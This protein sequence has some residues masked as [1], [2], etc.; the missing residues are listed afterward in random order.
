[1]DRHDCWGTDAFSTCYGCFE[2]KRSVHD[3]ETGYP[4]DWAPSSLSDRRK[5]LRIACMPIALFRVCFSSIFRCYGFEFKKSDEGG[6]DY[7]QQDCAHR[8]GEASD[9]E[10]SL[11][12]SD[13]GVVDSYFNYVEPEC[14]NLRDHAGIESITFE[15]DTL[16]KLADLGSSALDIMK[17]AEGRGSQGDPSHPPSGSLTRTEN[18]AFSGTLPEGTLSHESD[19]MTDVEMKEISKD[20]TGIARLDDGKAQMNALAAS[21]DLG[22]T[23]TPPVPFSPVSETI[24]S[25]FNSGSNSK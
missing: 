9:D 16:G 22:I 23:S 2:A 11:L 6:S 21:G 19:A 5:L 7:T 15:D 8:S 12:Q 18:V 20:D 10:S 25:T 13:S 1:M 3:E 24:V 14:A 4:R 17:K